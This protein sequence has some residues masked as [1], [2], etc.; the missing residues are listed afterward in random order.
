MVNGIPTWK[1]NRRLTVELRYMR[2]KLYDRL[3]NTVR[4]YNQHVARIQELD[5]RIERDE[6]YLQELDIELAL[7][8]S[9]DREDN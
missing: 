7:R 8:D 2:Q 9:K 1:I 3:K 5:R 4:E 6:Q